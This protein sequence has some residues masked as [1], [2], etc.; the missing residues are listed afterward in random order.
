MASLFP[1]LP[2]ETNISKEALL[3]AVRILYGE[4]ADC[5]VIGWLQ[6]LKHE[7]NYL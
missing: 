1:R 4:L 5:D 6:S 7:E 2:I 3:I